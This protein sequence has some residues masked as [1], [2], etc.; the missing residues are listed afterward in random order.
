ME[1]NITIFDIDLEED[2]LY[3][4]KKYNI[5]IN[6]SNDNSQ[7]AFSVAMG[8]GNIDKAKWLIRNGFDMEHPI[9]HVFPYTWKHP[10]LQLLMLEQGFKYINGLDDVGCS[11]ATWIDDVNVLRKYIE[12]GLHCETLD[13]DDASLI[14]GCDSVERL[15]LLISAGADI[16]NQNYKGENA[17]FNANPLLTAELIKRGVNVN[18]KNKEGQT[19]IFMSTSQES[20]ELLYNAGA[21]LDVLDKLGRNILFHVS[22]KVDLDFLVEKGVDVNCVS[23]DGENVLST[24]HVGDE[25]NIKYLEKLI[26]LGVNIEF[27]GNT[28]EKWIDNNLSKDMWSFI[29]PVIKAKQE[30]KELSEIMKKEPLPATVSKNKNKARL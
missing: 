14:V 22:Y 26:S 7:T 16:H 18:H 21:K 2:F 17:L 30:K 9:S 6:K 19:P 4:K 27:Y 3:Y 29:A 11:K 24:C 10:E 15:D 5:D 13:S 20:L 28:E 1:T 25:P 12:K 8:E 23:K